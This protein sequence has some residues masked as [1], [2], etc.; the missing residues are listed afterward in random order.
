VDTPSSILVEINYTF[1]PGSG[2]YPVTLN[3]FSETSIDPL[4]WDCDLA[5]L[6]RI[7]TLY[8]SSENYHPNGINTI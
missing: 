2:P 7:D 1:E 3:G 6:G 4:L 5:S 8:L